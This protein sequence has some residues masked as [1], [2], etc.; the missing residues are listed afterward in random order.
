[1]KII[2]A[3]NAG[4]CYGVKNA[5]KK[6]E[7]IK[8]DKIIYTLGE[9]IHNQQEIDRL[10]EKN[11]IPV[12]SINNIKDDDFL[13]IR[14]HGVGKTFYENFGKRENLIDATCPS[15]KL[16]HRLAEKYMLLGYQVIV[17]G[18]KNHPE[19]L[20]ILDWGG[21]DSLAVLKESDINQIN[22][23]KPILLLSQTTQSVDEFNIIKN[24]IEKKTE[25][26]VVKNTICKATRNRQSEIEE[27]SKV[28]DVMIIIGGKQSS[29][30]NKLFKIAKNFN[31]NSFFI[32]TYKDLNLDWFK[33]KNKIGISAGA[34]TP[35]WIIEEVIN[36]MMSEDKMEKEQ[37]MEE[38]LLEMDNDIQPGDIV[39]GIVIQ[40]DKENIVVDIG[41]K[42]EGII[43]IEEYT[44]EE[45]PNVGDKITAVLLQKSNSVGFPVLSKRKLLDRKN[46]ESQ[47]EALKTLPSKFENKEE[48]EG[49]VTSIAKS[50]LIVKI[51]DVEGF[52]PASQILLNG[53]AKS[54]DKY[55]GKKVRV[56]II[57]LDLKKRLPKIVLSQKVI[58]G[59]EREASSKDFWDIM[60][61]GKVVQGEV[62]M[63]ADFGAFVNLGY[64]DGLLHVSELSWNKRDNLKNMLA[65]GDK[66]NVK[67]IG[68]D[69][70][71]NKISLSLKALEEDPWQTFINN[72]KVGH[73][74]KGTVTSV[75][76]YGAFVSI[77]KFVEGLLHISEISHEKIA[78]VSDVLK[79]GDEIDVEILDIDEVNKK[80]SLSKKSLETPVKK[81]EPVEADKM[82][83]NDDA[84]TKSVTL[85]DILNQNNKNEE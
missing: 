8:T 84:E 83:Y 58:L 24:L 54:L 66:I 4:F 76:D 57:D 61:V 18:D 16:A 42:A 68:I 5:L 55:L 51:G 80:V 77:S 73:I 70:E 44:N 13:V 17:F 3:P 79:V 15:V 19:V 60:E 11:I 56:R 85:G 75:V 62:K 29:N 33:G 14:S 74:I 49:V 25:N 35:S 67:I 59:E 34:S 46:R 71:K 39:E 82:V 78:K 27:L 52:L 2:I 1:M 43:P 22:L 28:V 36:K 48:F 45:L 9:L 21:N 50:G 72:H 69:K 30:S 65:V 38:L 23:K 31:E 26:L 47:R 12:D 20:G 6:A 64:L 63:L 53:Y 81:D 40:V 7:E 10:K 37:T 41:L 32:E